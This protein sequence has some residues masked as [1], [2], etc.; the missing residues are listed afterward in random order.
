MMSFIFVRVTVTRGC[1]NTLSSEANADCAVTALRHKEEEEGGEGS[2]SLQLSQHYT[3]T[4]SQMSPEAPP[5]LT[6][7]P[8]HAA[9]HFTCW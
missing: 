7:T 5:T 9:N 1:M 6:A 3:H 4:P 2:I 8:T